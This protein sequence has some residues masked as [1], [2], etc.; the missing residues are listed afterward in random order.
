MYCKVTFLC[1]RFI[2]AN[3]VSDMLATSLLYLIQNWPVVI[4]FFN[5]SKVEKWLSFLAKKVTRSL[6]YNY[7]QVIKNVPL[8][9]AQ[10]LPFQY[11][12]QD[13]SSSICN[14]IVWSA[15]SIASYT[16]FCSLS[17]IKL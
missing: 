17:Y 10:P 5:Q 8:E 9:Q 6:R 15:V 14:V 4:L 11:S 2:Y 16:K 12:F 1:A 3:Y 7:Y 13:L